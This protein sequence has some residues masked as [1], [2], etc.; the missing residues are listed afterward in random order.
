MPS[1][2][3][4]DTPDCVILLGRGGTGAAAREALQRL[5][6]ALQPRLPGTEVL[7]AFVDRA[8]PSL[9]E[10]LDRCAGARSVAV[11]PLL[12]PDE[13]ALARWLHKVAMRWRAR[14]TG[15]LPRIVFAPPLMAAERLP[16]L[17]RELVA[18]ALRAE[19][20]A[21]TAGAQWHKDPV[22][23]SAVPEHQ[24]HVLVCLGPRCTALGAVDVWQ[25]LGECL[26]AEP[27]LGRRVR[28]LQTS[29]Q[30]PCNHGPLAIVYPE[31][32]WYG[33]LD[34]RS[35]GP[36]LEAHFLEGRPSAEHVVHRLRP[37]GGEERGP[38]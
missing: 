28:P 13:P 5:A 11:L 20:V 35:L 14:R 27:E 26:K 33:R 17:A 30:Y 18:Q 24:H 6:E 32:V 29:C 34:A 37:G 15:A 31:G 22:A 25:R 19:D 23:W 1:T 38:V 7:A 12:A 10:A 21:E 8:A 2:T 4:P 16:E 3:E 36:V 9:P